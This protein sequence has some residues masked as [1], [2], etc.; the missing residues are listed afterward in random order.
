VRE[1]SNLG[2]FWFPNLDLVV[3]VKPGYGMLFQGLEEHTGTPFYLD[4]DDTSPIPFDYVK[5]ARFNIIAYPKH[6]MMQG[7]MAKNSN[8]NILAGNSE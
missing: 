4:S 1:S 6:V 8:G 7:R 3:P 5:E 2:W